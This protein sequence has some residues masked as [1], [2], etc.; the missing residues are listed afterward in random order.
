MLGAVG[1]KEHGMMGCVGAGSKRCFQVSVA[2]VNPD[3]SFSFSFSR[4]LVAM[5]QRPFE[6][7]P[8]EVLSDGQ[9]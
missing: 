4:S 5:L 9:L 3:L 1:S 2:T 7:V 8:R 6:L